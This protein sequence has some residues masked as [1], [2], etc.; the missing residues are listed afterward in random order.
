M[1]VALAAEPGQAVA[2][3]EELGQAVVEPGQAAE[4]A[5]ELGKAVEATLAE[6]ARNR[7]GAS[8]GQW[9]ATFFAAGE[10]S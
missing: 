8:S 9:S 2:V 4:V 5:E 6:A 1:A 7:S 10:L 3:A